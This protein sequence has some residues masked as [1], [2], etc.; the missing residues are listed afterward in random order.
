MSRSSSPRL[1]R[2]R[3]GAELKARVLAACAQPGASVRAIALEH[4][5]NPNVIH[6]WRRKAT[7]A[8]QPTA[9]F[10]AVPLS[11]D[12]QS[13]IRIDV[14]RTDTTITV[15]WPMSAAAHCGTWLREWLR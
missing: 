4:G 14:H 2:R 3:H 11:P 8:A 7:V 15:T 13:G 6:H 10:I 1:S 9:G 12:T 5:L